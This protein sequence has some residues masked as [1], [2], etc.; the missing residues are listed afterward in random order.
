[1]MLELREYLWPMLIVSL[2]GLLFTTI[3]H[4]YIIYNPLDHDNNIFRCLLKSLRYYIPYLII[5]VFLAIAGSFALFL[6]LLVVVIGIIFAAIYIFSLYLFI[7]P[8]MIVEGPSIANTISRT[9][10][11]A[12]RNFWANIGW[13]AVFVII[14]LVI[15]TVLS[16]FILLPFTGSFFKAFSD[17]G[18]AASL[19]DIAKSLFT[20]FFLH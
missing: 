8:V 7:L 3:L 4:Y 16:G 9:V 14:M 1:M 19:M 15:S 2:S 18:E 13:T 10:T 11:L 12:H 17:P 20:L 5:L 6:G